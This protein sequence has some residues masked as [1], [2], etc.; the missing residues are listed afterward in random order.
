[1][2]AWLE[3]CRP[4]VVAA[5]HRVEVA[6]LPGNNLLAELQALGVAG[7]RALFL[8]NP[9]ELGTGVLRYFRQLNV[10]RDA[11]VEHLPMVWFVFVHPS[12]QAD[13]GR[14]APDFIDYA[15]LRLRCPGE[16]R[17]RACCRQGRRPCLTE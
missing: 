17:C 16:G 10:Q 7:G 5:A 8:L 12:Q 14:E 3:D 6:S 11:L 4:S 1:L 13:L 9:G 15:S 2:L